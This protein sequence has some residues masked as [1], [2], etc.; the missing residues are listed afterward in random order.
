MKTRTLLT[1]PAIFAA[2]LFSCSKNNDPAPSDSSTL[3]KMS[4]ANA[5]ADASASGSGDGTSTC[6]STYSNTVQNPPSGYIPG[7]AE[8]DLNN[9]LETY[10]D[11]SGGGPGTVRLVPPA[12]PVILTPA[13]PSNPPINTTPPEPD[14]NL[15]FLKFFQVIGYGPALTPRTLDEATALFD[16]YAQIVCAAV[17]ENINFPNPNHVDKA[18]ASVIYATNHPEIFQS[19]E[20]KEEFLGFLGL[21]F[22]K[23]TFVI[24]R[25]RGR[26]DTGG[27]LY[28]ASKDCVNFRLRIPPLF[29]PM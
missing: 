26:P 25:G 23:P 9:C 1:L 12:P 16:R 11:I 3:E 5:L 28:L 21:V 17:A 14:D 8:T 19:A 13:P 18:L 20:E 10:W 29:P 4:A 7:T 24:T 27:I 22:A 15:A 6:F 2:L